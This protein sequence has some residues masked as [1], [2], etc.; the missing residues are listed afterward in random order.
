[1]ALNPTLTPEGAVMRMPGEFLV[2]VRT[3]CDFELVI[4]NYKTLRG[5]GNV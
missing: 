4:S 2:L 3:N 5:S 1:M